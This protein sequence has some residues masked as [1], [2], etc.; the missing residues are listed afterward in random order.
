MA[1]GILIAECIRDNAALNSL[2]VASNNIVGAG[3]AALA[4][5]VLSKPSLESFSRIPLKELRA[6]SLT[7]LDLYKRG[8]GPTEAAVLA[9]LLQIGGQTLTALK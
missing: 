4:A 8:L 3:A 1:S 6:S 2:T 5:S 7:K 9:G